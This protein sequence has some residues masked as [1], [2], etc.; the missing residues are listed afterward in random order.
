MPSVSHYAEVFAGAG[1]KDVQ[2]GIAAS[3]SDA[4]VFHA[5]IK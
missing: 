2:F 3:G 1:F 4:T 5:A